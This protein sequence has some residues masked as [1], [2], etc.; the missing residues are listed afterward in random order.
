[1]G[2]PVVI[3]ENVDKDFWKTYHDNK[4]YL[5]LFGMVKITLAFVSMMDSPDP[6]KLRP[7]DLVMFKDDQPEQDSA[8]ATRAGLYFIR[9]ISRGMAARQFLTTVELC[10]EGLA[11]QTGELR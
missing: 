6:F 8:E 2:E 5:A 4:T 3:C 10:R 9:K 11:D 1:M 7:L